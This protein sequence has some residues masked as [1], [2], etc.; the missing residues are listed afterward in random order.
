M[1]IAIGAAVPVLLSAVGA[2]VDGKRTAFVYLLIDVLGAVICGTVFYAGNAIAPFPFMHMTM[3]TFSVALLNSIFRLVM[4]L[5]LFPL[6]GVLEKITCWCIKD[7]LQPPEERPGPIQLEERFLPYPSLAISQCREYINAMAKETESSLRH[8]LAALRSYDAADVQRVR[9]LETQSDLYEDRIGSYLVKLTRNELNA[10]D[11]TEVS[12]FL[13][14]LPDLER[15][16]D[17]TL[18]I[19]MVAKEIHQK[20]IVYSDE[21]EG[22]L[23]VLQA[24][25][26]E[27]LTITV[28][29]F[30]QNDLSGAAK[31]EPLE[32]VIGSLCNQMKLH[33]VS[34]LQSGKCTLSQG[35]TFNDLLTSYERISAHCSN[36]ALAILEL[37]SDTFNPHEYFSNLENLKQKVFAKH[38][39]EFQQRYTL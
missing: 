7:P 36:I 32:K 25:V 9:E 19:A 26:T 6:I 11:N 15:I 28:D 27:I 34:R 10:K 8:A 24:A 20:N 13:H 35:F 16:S 31:V 38:L 23:S 18:N 2:N 3:T 1:G 21:A 4:V 33:H 22:E 14:T 29:A 37:E 5:V 17:H 12:K 39:E 30:I